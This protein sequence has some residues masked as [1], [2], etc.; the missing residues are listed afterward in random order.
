MSEEIEQ[1]IEVLRAIYQ[2][3]LSGSAAT[4]L[5]LD[6]RPTPGSEEHCELKLTFTIPKTY[7][8]AAPTVTATPVKGVTVDEANKLL[9]ILKN[10]AAENIGQQ[11]VFTLASAAKE[12]LDDL[13]VHYDERHKKA[14][15]VEA[16]R[17]AEKEAAAER[18]RERA[19]GTPVTRAT[20]LAWNAKFQEELRQKEMA[21]AKEAAAVAAAAGLDKEKKLT[22]RAL[23]ESDASLVMSDAALLETFKNEPL[24]AD[25]AVPAALL[26]DPDSAALF[27]DAGLDDDVNDVAPSPSPAEVEAASK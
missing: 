1:E 22:G 27:D 25:V 7:P 2:D 17:E 12:W 5:I 14:Q 8:Q 20:F 21:A 16:A 24:P 10:T 9:A 3:E 19:R 15:E 26:A 6:V 23:F 18:E 4:G 11:M 13:N